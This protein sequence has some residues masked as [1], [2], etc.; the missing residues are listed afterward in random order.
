MH[1]GKVLISDTPKAITESRN[2]ATLE[3][4]FVAFLQDAIG[5]GEQSAPQKIEKD[6]AEPKA[7]HRKAWP[8]WLPNL[9]RM[10][11]YTRREALELK[12]D[13]Y[14]PRCH[15]GQ[16]HSHVRYR[17][18]HQSRRREADICGS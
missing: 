2:A 17:P 3:D 14:G 1:A 4:A 15:S 7:R 18:R 10:F 11:A 16:R 6:S 9:R 13:R 5:E 8:S 12:R